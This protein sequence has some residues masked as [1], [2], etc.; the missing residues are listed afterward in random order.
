M[1]WGRCERLHGTHPRHIRMNEHD[2]PIRSPNV[3]AGAIG[4][5]RTARFA[6]SLSFA[7]GSLS[8]RRL[9]N[10]TGDD[11]QKGGV[12]EI[13]RTALPFLRGAGV[14]VVW[15][16]LATPS[17]ARPALEY[18]HVLAHGR[19]PTTEWR[20]ELPAMAAVLAEFAHDGAGQVAASL[21]ASDMVVLHDTQAAPLASE[22]QRW[23]ERLIWHA[24]IGT[25]DHNEHVDAY[26]EVFG[27]KVAAA[28]VRV[29][30]RREFAPEAL[31]DI[32][33]YALPGID[34]SSDKS[35]ELS[36]REAVARLKAGKGP[37]GWIGPRP[38]L[39][40]DMFIALQL[41]RWDPLKDMAGALRVLSI[42]AA[43]HRDL[44]GLVVGPS[45]QSAAERRELD[46]CVAERDD[47]D[48]AVRGRLHIGVIED[49]GG[50]DHDQ[51]V[52]ALQSSADVVIQ[53]SVQEGFGLTVT[54]ALMRGK[55]VVA[56][57]VGGIPLQVAH[58]RTGILVA[59]GAS[60]AA[61]LEPILALASDPALRARL[62]AGA[63][64]SALDHHAIDRTLGAVLAGVAHALR[65]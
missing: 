48:H 42:A 46:L 38:E 26:W 27:P 65:C 8:G 60:D 19:P 35:A 9:V 7:A 10:I 30:Y 43:H 32:S 3:L 50:A 4:P 23:R 14:D 25:G 52:R 54:E 18:F 56:S 45:A 36:K 40:P 61:W 33:V 31:R 2:I 57:A 64:Q 34:P 15:L 17:A 37:L 58:E 63:R 28:G 39:R 16:D 21:R 20:A 22:L 44:V 24:H 5:S 47:A 62:G 51:A 1:W 55:A 6:E 59:A 41:S 49:C 53:K 29:F 12:Y 11:R 13:L